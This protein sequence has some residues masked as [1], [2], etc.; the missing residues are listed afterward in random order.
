[1]TAGALLALSLM[2]R[3]WS[4]GRIGVGQ[5]EA[6][7]L[8]VSALPSIGSIIGFLWSHE[9]HP[10]L[11]YLG[12]HLLQTAG[13][14]IVEMMSLV[15]LLGSIAT[16]AA[17]F[18]LA[19][20]S[21]LRGAGICSALMVGLSMPLV[22]YSV[23]LRPYALVSFLLLISVGALSLGLR[24]GSWRWRALWAGS[25]LLMLY[26]HHLGIVIAAA[27]TV[28]LLLIALRRHILRRTLAIWGAW[29]AAALLLA[30]PDAVMAW[31]QSQVAGYPVGNSVALFQP[32]RQFV[33]LCWSYPAELLVSVVAGVAVTW[34]SM[35]ASQ[36][37]LGDPLRECVGVTLVVLLLLMVLL[38]YRAGLLVTHVVLAVAPL[39]ATAAG[40]LAADLLRRRP[41]MAGIIWLEFLV[42][43]LA[44]GTTQSVGFAK[45]NIDLTGAYISAEA[46]PG[47][48]VV[49]ASGAIGVALNRRLHSPVTHID[50]PLFTAVKTYPF[51]HEFER[52]ADSGPL[53]STLDT[54]VSACRAHRRVWFVSGA[55]WTLTSSA[56][57]TLSRDKFGAS[58][59]ASWARASFIHQSLLKTFGAPM[60]ASAPN[61]DKHGMEMVRWDR[62]GR[63]N[64]DAPSSPA[65]ACG[66]L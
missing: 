50:Y 19:H 28:A 57:R 15:L 14:P 39:G 38:A 42:V 2:L 46:A 41:P 35:R 5:D 61:V 56:P 9:S 65:A 63:V 45:T 8:H 60:A 1:M 44:A 62:F 48:V 66:V 34:R 31:H 10:P 27:E 47:D 37:E 51:D 16:V 13:L 17:A 11:L 26:L 6:Q 7:F 36:Q 58:V 49:V 55:A 40:I 33:R 23:Q 20:H 22:I 59:Q 53:Q 43:C 54:I 30:L 32:I 29:W 25:L 64:S 12:A 52:M 24:T 4:P 3:V 21:G 18:W